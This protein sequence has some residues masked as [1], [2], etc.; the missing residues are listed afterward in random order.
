MERRSGVALWR[1]IADRLRQDVA[2]GT[3]DETER[4]PAEVELAARFGVNRHTLR[5]AIALLVHEGVLRSEQGRGTFVEKSRRFLY[6]IGR[7]TR[8]LEGLEGQAGDRRGVLVGHAYEEADRDVAEALMIALRTPVLRMETIGMAD[9]KPLS[10]ATSYFD[11][12]RF[13]GFE[14]SFAG[15]GSVTASL[16]TF[17]IDDYVRR[18]TVISAIHAS[19]SDLSDLRLSP[20]A[21]VLVTVAVNA[22][23]DGVPVQYS[24]TRF[25]ASF[26]ELSVAA[27]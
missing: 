9:G 4:L 25:P 23:L 10:R 13:E 7:K 20:G 24:R 26:V 8:F 1:Q 19:A 5:E 6:P 27:I 2:S 17:G 11:A 12:T 21:I 22:T 15:T 14:R 3:F 16:R 18:S